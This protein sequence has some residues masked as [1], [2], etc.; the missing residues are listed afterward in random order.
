MKAFYKMMYGLPVAQKVYASIKENIKSITYYPGMG[1]VEPTLADYPQCF[2]TFVQHPNLKI[3]YWIED[4]YVKIAMF[5][6]T[7]QEP[8]K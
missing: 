6:D 1:Y 3:V 4:G 5:F 7:R 8:E 2:R